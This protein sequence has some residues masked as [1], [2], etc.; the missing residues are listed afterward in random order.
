VRAGARGLLVLVHDITGLQQSSRASLAAL[1]LAAGTFGLLGSLTLLLVAGRV[2]RHREEREQASRVRHR[3][4]SEV[5]ERA[6]VERELKAAQEKLDHR[7][8]ERTAELRRINE[9]DDTVDSPGYALNLVRIPIS[10]LPG[11]NTQQGHGAEVT[12]IG[13]AQRGDDLLPTTFRNMVINDLIDLLAPGLTF[14]VNNGEVRTAL[15]MT[16]LA[17]DVNAFEARVLPD[18]RLVPGGE[19]NPDPV[20]DAQRRKIVAKV[21][22]AMR[23]H[24]V[25]VSVPTAKMR[26]ARMPL[27]PEELV[28]V[29]GEVQVALMLRATFEALGANPANRPCLEYNDVR[30]FLGEELQAAYDFLS[31]ER[32]AAVENYST[33]N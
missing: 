12:V 28:D 19:N 6:R 16:G 11:K 24:T 27:P 4:E 31:Q 20:G 18:G 9:G 25:S 15:C 5:M 32:Q 1:A 33:S 13:E 29:V 10:I 30:G 23:S 21:R 26:R 3:L 8:A 7:V 14:A 2:G 17:Q 22:K